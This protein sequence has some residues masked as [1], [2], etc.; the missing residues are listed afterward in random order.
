M[1]NNHDDVIDVS[2]A[3]DASKLLSDMDEK[4]KENLYLR[5]QLEEKDNEVNYLKSTVKSME[6]SA[7]W[8]IGQLIGG[9]LSRFSGAT[10]ILLYLCGKIVPNIDEGQE[11]FKNDLK[12]ILKDREGN[13]KAIIVYPPTVDW[14]IPLFQ[15][16]QQLALELSKIGYLFFYSTHNLYDKVNNFHKINPNCYLTN[17]F[18]LLIKELP[19]IIFLVSST[20]LRLDIDFLEAGD[21]KKLI[22]Y[23]YIDEIHPDISG[24]D[25]ELHKQ[26]LR[27]HQYMIK[28]SDIAIATADKLLENFLKYRS[29]DIYLIPNGVDYNHFHINRD[30]DKVPEEIRHILRKGYPIIGYYGAFAKWLDYELIIDIAKKRPNYQIVLIGWDYDGSAKSHDLDKIKNIYDIGA[31][32]YKVLPE[33]AI[34][35]DVSIIP[36]ILNEVTESTSPIK[37]FEYMAL[38]SPI[39]TTDMRECRKYKSVLIGKNRDEFIQKLDE[40]LKLRNDKNYLE[41]LDRDAKENTWASRASFIDQLIKQKA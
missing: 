28:Q 31:K 14:N 9:Y 6:S 26:M 39:V 36:F 13:I 24:Q 20:R 10:R 17:K 3:L 4:I 18:D 11:A 37:I 8:R 38:N 29:E 21:N 23:D 35:F 19:E 15:R 22:L 16:P 32:N 41:L 40:A 1:A 33:Y 7:S 12:T 5:R 34:W 30:P 27:R 2:N 25:A